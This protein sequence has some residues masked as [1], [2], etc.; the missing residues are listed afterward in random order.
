[1]TLKKITRAVK[2]KLLRSPKYLDP[3]FDKRGAITPEQIDL[4]WKD[5]L[6]IKDYLIP[7]RLAFFEEVASKAPYTKNIKH[8][9]DIGCGSGHILAHYAKLHDINEK[10]LVANEIS[11]Y[12]LLQVN[13][14][15]PK[16]NLL[17]ADLLSLPE[18]LQP[19]FDLAIATE[20][21]EHLEKPERYLSCLVS[22]LKPKG[23]ALITIPDGDV[24]NWQGHFNF[25]N[26][27]QFRQFVKS[28]DDIAIQHF[29]RLSSDDLLFIIEKIR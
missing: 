12:A 26:E 4:F 1:M 7:E 5:E 20:I 8:V 6:R 11:A 29:E 15:L 17:R 28:F 16:T 22:I 23:R 27:K 14:L 24:D 25:W 21:F 13:K 2:T 10:N 3:D 9:I 18:L 19:N